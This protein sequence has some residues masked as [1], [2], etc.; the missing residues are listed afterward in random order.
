VN[1]KNALQTSGV[2]S[3]TVHAWPLLWNASTHMTCQ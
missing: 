3:Q 1:L 2:L